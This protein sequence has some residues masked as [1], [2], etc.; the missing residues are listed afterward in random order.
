MYVCN[1][2]R[3]DNV[4]PTVYWCLHVICLFDLGL[5]KGVIL[6]HGALVSDVSAVCKHIVSFCLLIMFSTDYGSKVI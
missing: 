2:T 5:P 3:P 1:L 4:M 6:T